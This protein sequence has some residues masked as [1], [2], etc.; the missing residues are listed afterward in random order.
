MA[1]IDSV[2]LKA[3]RREP[4]PYTPIWIMRQAGRY[5]KSYR[6]I[7]SKVSF[8]ELCKNKELASQVT[9][10]AAHQLGVDAAIIFSDILL[11]AEPMGLKLEYDT[12][13]GPA[14]RG[15]LATKQQID[16]IPEVYA[17]ETLGFVADAIRLARARLKP[18]LPL[19]GFCGA[20]FTLGAYL[21]EGGGSKQFVKTKQWIHSDPGAWNA[22]MEKLVR[23]LA[24]YLKMQ[25]AAGADALQ[26]FDSWA[27]CL[28]PQEYRDY[29]LPHS[30]A[31][32]R[33]V[34]TEVPVI[35]FGTGTAPF[36]KEFASAGASVIGVDSQ[37]PLDQAWQIIGPQKAIQGNL[38]PEVLC[39]TPEKIEQ[40][41][42]KIL[43]Q[44]AGRPGHI[45]NLGHGILP[46]TPETNAVALVEM[47]HR[48]SRK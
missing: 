10:D 28:S 12:P 42:K 44:A 38:D 41:V 22:L 23:A 31:L 16:Q 47:V 35:Y 27:G 30:Q 36:L 14:I 37:I 18:E 40:A 24:G 7:R 29:A 1:R 39:S 33:A 45:F 17:E 8:M 13:Q 19:I 34:G 3:C 6:D 43:D 5:L 32:I 15:G 11:I 48:L 26:I 4:V 2:F 21:I 25:V 46:P 20:P 9:V